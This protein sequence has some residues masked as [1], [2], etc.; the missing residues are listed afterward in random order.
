[1]KATLVVVSWEGV[2]AQ[3]SRGPSDGFVG[4]SFG[5]FCPFFVTFFGQAKKVRTIQRERSLVE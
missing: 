1:V 2:L 5:I 3:K 4:R